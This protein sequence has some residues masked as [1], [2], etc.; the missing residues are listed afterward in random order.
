MK[1]LRKSGGDSS[2]F[3]WSLYA[4]IF[5]SDSVLYWNKNGVIS[6]KRFITSMR[7][8]HMISP[9]MQNGDEFYGCLLEDE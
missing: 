6:W 5:S 4:S 1:T 9:L 3:N 8:S 7:N 2:F